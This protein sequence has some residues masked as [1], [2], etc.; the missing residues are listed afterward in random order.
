ME[1]F[2]CHLDCLALYIEIGEESEQANSWDW[3]MAKK[4]ASKQVLELL[5]TTS[6][7]LQK[8]SDELDAIKKKDGSIFSV[9]GKPPVVKRGKKRNRL[10]EHFRDPNE[11]I[12]Q[13]IAKWFGEELYFGTIDHVSNYEEEETWWHVLYDDDDQEEFDIRQVRSGIEL[14]KKNKS[15]DPK[16]QDEEKMDSD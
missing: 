13:R 12:N 7:K 8:R 10:P 6:S 1:I 5:P 3:V 9:L 2:Y 11:F 14:Y 16:I 4:E 15:D